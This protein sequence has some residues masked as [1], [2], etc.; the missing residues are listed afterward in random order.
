MKGVVIP[1]I[2]DPSLVVANM[3]ITESLHGC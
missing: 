3:M 1:V 2:S